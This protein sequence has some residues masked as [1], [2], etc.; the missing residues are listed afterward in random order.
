MLSNPVRGVNSYSLK[1]KS[2]G[3]GG[4]YYSNNYSSML[5]GNGLGE[6]DVQGKS[7]VNSKSI[8]NNSYM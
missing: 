2:S 6:L 4:Q 5:G 1:Q 7:V 8:I 3:L